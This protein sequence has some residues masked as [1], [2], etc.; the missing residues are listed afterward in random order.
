MPDVKLGVT[1]DTSKASGAFEDLSDDIDK[2]LKKA[3]KS[4]NSFADNAAQAISGMKDAFGMVETALGYLQQA[5]EATIGEAMKYADTVRQMSRVSGASAEETSRVIQLT[6]DLGLEISDLEVAMRGA[7]T[8][9]IVVTTE[10]LAKMSDE[11]IKL[12]PGVERNTYLLDNFGRAGLE[13]AKILEQGSKRIKEMSAAVESNMIMTQSAM[14]NYLGYSRFLDMQADM[15]TGITRDIAIG[16]L[17]NMRGWLT[18]EE[19]NASAIKA[20]LPNLQLQVNLLDLIGKSLGNVQRYQWESYAALGKLNPEMNLW[21]NYLNAA[22]TATRQ[23]SE[24][25]GRY[26]E[27]MMFNKLAAS[28]TVEEQRQLAVSLGLI[29][30]ASALASPAMDEIARKFKAGEITAYDAMIQI[31][32]LRQEMAA[33][34]GMTA[35]ITINTVYPN[36]VPPPGTTGVEGVSHPPPSTGP[37]NLGL[38]PGSTTPPYTG[39]AGGGGG[40]I[41]LAGGADFT[42]PPGYPNDTFPMRV[43]SGEHVTV[44]PR[45]EN[46]GTN[47][48]LNFYG[49]TSPEGAKQGVLAG[50]RAAGKQ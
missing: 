34:N 31:A 20:G 13:M 8:K 40:G 25:M 30:D 4:T 49:P 29:D 35:T 3:G 50:L 16:L 7:A 15:I 11:Y 6:D 46:S 45:G 14:D 38:P 47:I 26:T 28:M 5:Y 44:T 33:L 17:P 10:S 22:N 23:L 19:R 1:A 18:A 9:G 27:Q 24:S 41:Q 32:A 36:G 39:P 42:V 48:T 12:A 2:S 43:Q 37:A 21:S